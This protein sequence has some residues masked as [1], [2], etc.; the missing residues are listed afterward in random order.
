M[1]THPDD[2]VKYVLG[3]IEYTARLFRKREKRSSPHAAQYGGHY[4]I[5]HHYKAEAWAKAAK[6][7]ETLAKRLRRELL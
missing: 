3:E 6:D 4:G 2:S 5:E 7:L 1:T